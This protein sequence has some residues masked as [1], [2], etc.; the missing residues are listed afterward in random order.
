MALPGDLVAVL[1]LLATALLLDLLQYTFAALIWGYYA[2]RKEKEL[3]HR[4]HEDPMIEP[5]PQLNWPGIGFFWGKLLV[6]VIGYAL[7]G[8]FIAGQL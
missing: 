4:F 5:P 6:L 8:K 2:R 3:R 1:L 7:L